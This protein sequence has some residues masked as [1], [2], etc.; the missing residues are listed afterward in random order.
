MTRTDEINR[1]VWGLAAFG[2][3]FG[4][5]TL[6]S[7]PWSFPAFVPAM[8]G[9]VFAFDPAFIPTGAIL[10]GGLWTLNAM[11]FAV[12]F[13]DGHWRPLTRQLDLALTAVWGAVLLWLAIGPRI[14]LAEPTDSS[15]KGA[16]ILVMVFVVA[17]LVS[18]A[19]RVMRG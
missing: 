16:L 18:K 17:S 1:I 8:R 3:L 10:V 6:V 12:V 7:A 15:A 2:A 19:R 4:M 5:A 11:L 13:S 9:D 14:F